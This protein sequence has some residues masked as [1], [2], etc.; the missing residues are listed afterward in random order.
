MR[1]SLTCSTSMTVKSVLYLLN[2]R[3]NFINFAG[4]KVPHKN[5]W[6]HRRK[7]LSNRCVDTISVI[8]RRCN[9]LRFFITILKQDLFSK[10]LKCLKDGTL[11]RSTASTNMNSASSRSHAIFTLHIKQQR[12]IDVGIWCFE[13]L[14][15]V[16]LFSWTS[17][18]VQMG[19]ARPIMKR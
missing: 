5:P 10:T 4:Q 19:K 13:W 2:P 14:D 9:F 6:K 1:N 16:S 3:S 18:K 17:M 8:I 11:C 7:H 15:W 12:L